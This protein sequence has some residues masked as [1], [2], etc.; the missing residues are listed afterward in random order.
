[1]TVILFKKKK[2]KAI[3]YFA[4]TNR[5]GPKVIFSGCMKSVPTGGVHH[6]NYEH[7][8]LTFD[9]QKVFRYRGTPFSIMAASELHISLL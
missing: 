8:P 5:T 9:N 6:I 2:K 1:M 4:S 7:E 3:I